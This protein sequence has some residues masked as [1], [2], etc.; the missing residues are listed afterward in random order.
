MVTRPYPE[1]ALAERER[2]WRLVPA[3]GA[4]HPPAR[5]AAGV[6][7]P[8]LLRAGEKLL[9]VVLLMAFAGAFQNQLF[10]LEAR[11]GTWDALDEA[12]S[13]ALRLAWLPTHLAVVMLCLPHL[14]PLWRLAR[15]V[16][17]LSLLVLLCA[18][19]VLWSVA[20]VDTLRRAAALAVTTMFGLYLAQRFDRATQ[21]R[22]LAWALGIAVLVSLVAL[23]VVPEAVLMT[24]KHAGR[25]RGLFI[26]KNVFGFTLVIE[27][28]ALLLLLR[29]SRAWSPAIAAALVGATLALALTGSATSWV[30]AAA[31]VVLAFALM[32]LR[33][34][35]SRAPARLLFTLAIVLT[36]LVAVP[37]LVDPV[38]GA[39]GR[40]T[41]LSG[42][43]WL[44][45]EA[46]ARA[47]ARPL[48]GYGFGAAWAPG[49]ELPLIVRIQAG[50]AP[51][52]AH[53]G[54]LEL[55]LSLGAVGLAVFL[56]GLGA[57]FRRLWHEIRF[58]DTL[59]AYWCGL[60]VGLTLL[61]NLT[62]SYLPRQ[63]SLIWVLLVSTAA[64]LAARP[65][66]GGR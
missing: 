9:V 37:L 13:T 64:G 30:L 36:G 8:R 38:A 58:G 34:G 19:S 51:E 44:W 39:L 23:V 12:R 7:R 45:Q 10:G 20:P 56:L 40:D 1:Q 5:P 47:A 43:L 60:F 54:Y 27:L 32:V 46:L 33:S 16:R 14:G 3:H 62:E 63:N 35:Q 41:T 28:L 17:W 66:P 65:P 50:W 22:L 25:L 53:N 21:L 15:S 57:I 18:L 26:H 52:D 24:E 42:R 55:V 2:A 61:L 29:T 59:G 48:L 49:L 31:L 6:L 11:E 4:S